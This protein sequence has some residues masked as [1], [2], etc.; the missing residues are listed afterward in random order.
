M[1]AR[2]FPKWVAEREALRLGGRG[3]IFQVA[4]GGGGKQGRWRWEM[5]AAGSRGRL[6]AGRTSRVDP[7]FLK[8][9]DLHPIQQFLFVCLF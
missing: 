4:A 8:E 9:E 6:Q 5:G 7:R 1:F 3:G 2:S